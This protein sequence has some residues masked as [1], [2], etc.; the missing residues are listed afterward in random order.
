MISRNSNALHLFACR[1]NLSEMIPAEENNGTVTGFFDKINTL[2][3]YFFPVCL[4]DKFLLRFR[5]L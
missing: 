2:I 3:N 1:M 5:S 4:F